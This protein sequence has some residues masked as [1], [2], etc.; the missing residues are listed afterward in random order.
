MLCLIKPTD[1][2]TQAYR[3]TDASNNPTEVDLR[4]GISRAYYS[5]FNEASY[6]LRTK[7]QRQQPSFNVHSWVKKEIMKIDRK[8]GLDYG[9]YKSKRQEADYDIH[10]SFGYLNQRDSETIVR[11][12][13]RLITDLQGK[14]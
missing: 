2:L 1:F 9:S 12:I 5:L 14:I 11:N 10:C 8:A 6:L 4:S 3:L 7:R 13:D